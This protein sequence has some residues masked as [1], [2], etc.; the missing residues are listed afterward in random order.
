M[1]ITLAIKKWL[2]TKPQETDAFFVH[3]REF[4]QTIFP[5]K[6]EYKYITSY[7]R[8]CNICGDFQML[9]YHRFGAIRTEWKSYNI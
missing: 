6:H 3:I 7:K 4:V 8:Q 1:K 9:V 2:Y 5:C